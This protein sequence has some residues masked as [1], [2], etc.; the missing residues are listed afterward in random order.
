MPILFNSLSTFNSNR[1]EVDLPEIDLKQS[2]ITFNGG[3]TFNFV[4]ALSSCLDVKTKNYTNFYLSPRTLFSDITDSDKLE[5]TPQTFLTPIFFGSAEGETLAL[6]SLPLSAGNPSSYG[7]YY[8]AGFVQTTKDNADKYRIELYNG[9]YCSISYQNQLSKSYLVVNSNKECIFD[10]AVKYDT[11]FSTSGDIYF[12]YILNGDRLILLKD[13]GAT[14]YQITPIN[15]LLSAVSA[16]INPFSTIPEYA[17][18]ISNNIVIDQEISDNSSYINYE[19]NTLNINQDGS[20][21]NLKN[22]YLLY[23]NLDSENLSQFKVIVLKN[24]M[25]DNGA[26]YKSNNLALSS[27]S[28][29][30]DSRRYTSISQDILAL[31]DQDLVLNYTFNNKSIEMVPGVNYFTTEKSMFPFSQININD[32]TLI[33]SGAFSSLSPKYADRVTSIV[34]SQTLKEY[35]YLCTWLSGSPLSNS[36]IWVDRYYYPDLETKEAALAGNNIYNNTYDSFVE[37]LIISNATVK[38]NVE[39]VLYIDKVSDFVFTPNSE[40]I[41]ERIDLDKLE[42]IGEKSIG[43][44]DAGFYQTI[45]DN[46]GF[47]F[48]CNILNY[49]QKEFQKIYSRFNRINAGLT[50]SYNKDTIEVTYTVYNV[51]SKRIETVGRSSVPVI[52]GSSNNIVFSANHKTGKI[53]CYINGV[54]LFE[55]FISPLYYLPLFGDITAN[56]QDIYQSSDLISELTLTTQPL[57]DEEVELLVAKYND[58]KSEFSIS[59]PC[60]QRNKSDNISYINSLTT[61]LKSKSNSINIYIN[62]LNIDDEEL[63]NTIKASVESTIKELLPTNIEIN[64]LEIIS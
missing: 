29:L 35:R 43:A 38:N 44:R 28:K 46:N 60:G 5:L 2:Y 14:T 22:N 39:S 3:A 62:N 54:V 61:N 33:E 64:N 31:E 10:R 51:A 49:D 56:G 6:A 15:T 63:Q 32:S 48:A 41:Y 13:I 57:N 40:Y 7:Y 34:T 36:K 25:A 18:T 11:T 59:L 1:V 21:F 16:N 12:R 23:R 55:N 58:S 45:N 24:Q 20:I 4:D 17:L 50:V 47:C 37:T 9:E 30:L 53:I 42:F 26:L 52:K 8:K 19:P 27:E